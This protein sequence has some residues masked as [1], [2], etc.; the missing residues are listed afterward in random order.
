VAAA[1]IGSV[2]R[3]VFG[4]GLA[5]ALLLAFA[6]IF[7]PI[8]A[9]V[10]PLLEWEVL[11]PIDP[12]VAASAWFEEGKIKPTPRDEGRLTAVPLTIEPPPSSVPRAAIE[13][14]FGPAPSRSHPWLTGSVLLVYGIGVLVALLR[15]GR[16]RARSLRLVQVAVPAGPEWVASTRVRIRESDAI[17]LPIT[18]GGLF[19]VV[20][21][22]Q[23]GRAWPSDWRQAVLAHEIAHVRARDPLWQLVSELACAVYW[24]HPLAHLAAR[25]LRIER[26]LAADDAVLATGMRPSDYA[27]VLVEL[28]CVPTSPAAGGGAVIPLLTPSGL[29]ARLLGALDAARSRNARLWVFAVAAVVGVSAFMPLSLA[30]PVAQIRPEQSL[31]RRGQVIGRVVDDRDGKPV[32]GAE[33]VFRFQQ[34]LTIRTSVVTSDRGGWFAYPRD[35]IPQSDFDVYARK[36]GRAA[37]KRVLSMP[38]GTTLPIAMDLRAAHVVSGVVQLPDGSPIAKATVKVLQADRTAPP[39][40]R[41]VVATTDAEGRWTVPG[42]MYGEFRLLVEAPWGVAAT[43]L[44]IVKD[45]DIHDLK[46][47]LARDWPIT[48]WLRDEKGRPVAGAQLEYGMA[49]Y[50]V[51]PDG[52][53]RHQR[54]GQR[55]LNWDE[56]GQDGSFR[57]MQQGAQVNAKGQSADGDPVF[58]SFQDSGER[59]L[60]FGRGPGNGG[61]M[62][63]PAKPPHTVVMNRAAQVSGVVVDDLGKPVPR[64]TVQAQPVRHGPQ[65]IVWTET[66]AEGR[67]SL[68][69]I[70]ATAV[71]IASPY[72]PR[73]TPGFNGK[74]DVLDLAPG[75]HRQ[76]VRVRFYRPPVATSHRP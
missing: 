21:V 63:E 16:A 76:G 49:Y 62:V 25:Q 5:G 35:E 1:T 66:D 46:V 55:Y 24:F 73:R 11:P 22:P 64:T 42:F 40:G 19:P 31:V 60:F 32:A 50:S 74:T 30:L 48:G 38:Y 20:V 43:Q 26:E 8:L 65:D 13:P 17:E 57:L 47:V 69:N 68:P 53:H 23:A 41:L 51:G 59:R 36:D 44:I 10:L 39:P 72:D 52:W 12:A 58:A 67:F 3:W 14:P 70:F 18:V 15:L 7:S 9:P 54:A 34:R 6:P 28:A 33:V 45:N 37:R 71:L 75:E 29:K 2:R 61:P 56:S 4:V 27:G